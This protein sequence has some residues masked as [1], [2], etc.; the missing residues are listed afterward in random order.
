MS[1]DE[2]QKPEKKVVKRKGDTS[3]EMP[4]TSKKLLF[5]PPQFLKAQ[6]IKEPPKISSNISPATFANND[7]K[8]LTEYFEK[9]IN[10]FET[11]FNE[12]FHQIE[13]KFEN[14]FNQKFNY[15]ERNFSEFREDVNSLTE[16]ILRHQLSK[17]IS[18]RYV[19]SFIFT[20]FSSLPDYLINILSE[21]SKILMEKIFRSESL[22]SE[23][24]RKCSKIMEENPKIMKYL[25]KTANE[26]ISK[27]SPQ[28]KTLLT[29]DVQ[30][31]SKAALMEQFLEAIKKEIENI[32]ET[33][34][35][36]IN[37]SGSL[38][39]FETGNTL[40]VLYKVGEIK[41]RINPSQLVKAISQL[42]RISIV[43][44]QVLTNLF[45]GKIEILNKMT[46]YYV[47]MEESLN[48]M[49]IGKKIFEFECEDNKKFQLFLEKSII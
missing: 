24:N 9:K 40:F 31:E 5:I 12:K 48:E 19:Q 6:S 28:I 22:Y 49:V 25:G 42:L 45:E 16:N 21:D 30:N 15:I 23:L 4:P 8:L 44:D 32:R 20:K 38:D 47:N 2:Q 1:E 14:K 18:K 33:D 17:K 3:L 41:K 26:Q 39:I 29:L 27:M 43:I 34:Q 35:F 13:A 7:L 36:E 10:H 46:L 37:I 11:Q